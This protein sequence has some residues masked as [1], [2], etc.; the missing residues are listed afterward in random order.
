MTKATLEPNNKNNIDL[1]L[2]PVKTAAPLAAADIYDLIKQSEYT[3]LYV[4]SDNIKNAIAELNSVLK[5]LQAGQSGREIRYQILERKDATIKIIIAPDEMSAEAEI[6]AAM[7]GKHLSAKGILLAAQQHG[8]VKGFTKEDLV[9]LAHRAAKAAPG[10]LVKQRIAQGLPAKNGRDAYIKHL[11]ESGQN[12]ILRPKER[13]DGTVDMRDF[14]DIVCVKVGQPLVQKIPLTHGKPGFTVTGTPLLPEA[15]NDISIDVG[16]GTTLSPKDSNVIV[17]TKVGMPRI[18]DTSIQVDD[19]YSINNVDVS[20]GNITFQ[21]SV[22]IKCNVC[23]GMKVIATGDINIGGYVE[24]AY[25]DA[26]GDVTIAGG[27]IGRK[28]DVD[29]KAVIDCVMSTRICAKGS[30][31]AKYCQ[32]AELTVG[33]DI[34]IENQLLH[35]ILNVGGKVWVGKIGI[36]KA[37]GKLIGGHINATESIH[38]GIIGA[39]AGSHTIIEFRETIENYKQKIQTLD[40]NIKIQQAKADELRLAENKLKKV[41]KAQRNEDLLK[42]IHNTY[43]HHTNELVSLTEEKHQ[44]EIQMQLYMEEVFVEGTEKVYHG[45]QMKIGDYIERTKRVYGPVRLRYF[46]RKVLIDPIIHHS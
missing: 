34:T 28:Q 18:S 20:T 40:E 33:K 25:I 9:K 8:V 3:N 21:G 23:E 1:V 46:E 16:D 26:G 11:V 32:Y 42:K 12:R 13:D 6:T 44:I 5:P 24:S 15:G 7:G 27:I 10:E 35:S 37:N 4:H 17:S 38:A 36:P 2:Q 19:V 30:L 14:G 45:V 43:V 22:I 41:P 39:T 29:N 31:Y